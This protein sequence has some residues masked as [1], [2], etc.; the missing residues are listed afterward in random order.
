MVNSG[1]GGVIVSHT[2]L[3]M[4]LL[5]CSFTKLSQ[6]PLV[7]KAFGIPIRH[8]L[9]THLKLLC[10]ADVKYTTTGLGFIYAWLKL[11]DL[12]QYG[13]LST[14]LC[15]MWCRG[16]SAPMRPIPQQLL[17]KFWH[18]P[19]IKKDGYCPTLSAIV[20]RRI[21]RS[22]YQPVSDKVNDAGLGTWCT[23][24]WVRH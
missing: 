2:R 15:V 13:G 20:E 17:R 9:C 11:R 7:K 1:C 23:D 24:K 16:T 5:I 8:T 21:V 4:V 3:R 6:L 19:M 10:I 22:W 12:Y 18:T 14:L